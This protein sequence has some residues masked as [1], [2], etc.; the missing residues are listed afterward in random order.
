M[1][2]LHSSIVS[3]T[4]QNL[5]F[6]REVSRPR[7]DP[8]QTYVQLA[9]ATLRALCD[10][11][12]FVA[13]ERDRA[14]ELATELLSPW[15]HQRIG[16]RPV[17]ESDITDEHFPIEFSLAVEHGKPEIR[18]LFEAQADVF[19][20]SALWAAGWELSERI[21]SEHDGV[22]LERLR[23]I[24]D[25][26]EPSSATCRYAM[27]HCVSFTPGAKSKFKVYLNP[28]AQGRER[29]PVVIHDALRRLGFATAV[30]D[31]LDGTDER[32]EFRFFSLDLA[33]TEDARVKVYRV[34]HNSTR[35]QIESWLR[36]IPGYP[37]EMIEEFW[38]TLA[39]SQQRFTGLPISSYLSLDS[40]SER[41]SSGT[42]HFPVR[43]YVADDLEVNHR[44]RWFLN[45]DEFDIYDRALS[46]FATRPLA[47]GSGLHSYV[48]LRIHPGPRHVTIYLSPEAYEV[49]PPNR[50]TD[51]E[52][53][54]RVSVEQVQLSA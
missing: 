19:E 33:R 3:D 27:W 29:A 16:R 53:S 31:M 12:G 34:H 30:T 14:I 5:Q 40:R 48:A 23:S 32:C 6:K 1:L 17:G 54:G 44:L 21:A 7:R 41:P 15:G 36:C 2:S 51:R 52:I 13:D 35:S 46:D 10:N 20:Q 18:M 42:I 25:L 50:S 28:L 11:L 43:S 49:A 9:A 38:D 39:G 8:N 24:A 22:C 4:A 45:E 47:D 26:F 37:A